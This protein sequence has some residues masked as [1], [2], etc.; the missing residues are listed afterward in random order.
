LERA[1]SD[2]NQG[3]AR[4]SAEEL[5]YRQTLS[6]ITSPIKIYSYCKDVLGM[7]RTRNVVEVRT[8]GSEKAA[9]EA[10]WSIAGLLGLG[11]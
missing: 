9:S 10:R 8:R 7:E 5:S 4:L 3:I 1:L 6:T 11:N 2:I